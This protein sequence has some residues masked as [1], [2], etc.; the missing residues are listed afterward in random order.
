MKHNELME[1]LE[2]MGW[3]NHYRIEHSY[4]H[5]QFTH[6]D[7]RT[8]HFTE[9]IE[10]E[11]HTIEQWIQHAHP[12]MPLAKIRTMMS[13]FYGEPEPVTEGSD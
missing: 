5:I 8:K 2:L 7:Y 3:I 9:H 11:R 12:N 6:P 4:R 10:G 13:V 1:Y